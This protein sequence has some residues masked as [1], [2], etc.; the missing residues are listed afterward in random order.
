MQMQEMRLNKE[1]NKTILKYL[2][3]LRKKG[4][5]KLSTRQKWENYK[6]VEMIVNAGEKNNMIL[7]KDR[8][9]NVIYFIS[10]PI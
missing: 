8:I 1:L 5:R 4:F 10:T 6:F 7:V 2:K 3:G 9:K